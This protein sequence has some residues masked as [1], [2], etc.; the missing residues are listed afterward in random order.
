MRVYVLTSDPYKHLIKEFVERFSLDKE[1]IVYGYSPL[2]FGL[3]NNFS[4]VSLGKRQTS[5]SDGVIKMLETADPY[6]ILM[7]EDYFI[8]EIDEEMLKKAEDLMMKERPAKISLER[9]RK[10]G[11]TYYWKPYKDNWVIRQQDAPYLMSVEPSIMNR[12]VWKKYL[13]PGE[14]AWQSEVNSGKRCRN[15]GEAVLASTI[16]IIKYYNYIQKGRPRRNNILW[17]T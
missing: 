1:V 8:K 14:N 15:Q 16:P 7:L 12:D 9:A 2:G 11:K 3:P 5:W 13:I 4:F 10:T 6:F 17:G